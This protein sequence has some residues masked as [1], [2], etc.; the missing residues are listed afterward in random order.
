M[1]RTTL[2]RTVILSR[3]RVGLIGTGS[4]R[5]KIESFVISETVCILLCSIPRYAVVLL[6]S[7]C[8]YISS[9]CSPATSHPSTTS[10]ILVF[11]PGFVISLPVWYRQSSCGQSSTYSARCHERR[12]KNW[13]TLKLSSFFFINVH[14]F[15]M[16]FAVQLVNLT[17]GYF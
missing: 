3:G 16:R 7:S 9:K 2:N 13:Q 10:S 1:L 12:R 5:R 6:F 8:I 4:Y 17:A 15:A 14:R 11:Y